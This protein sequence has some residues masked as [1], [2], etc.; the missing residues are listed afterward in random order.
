MTGGRQP[1]RAL[2][3]DHQAHKSCTS[4]CM[5]S[6]LGV[7]HTH[8]QDPIDGPKKPQAIWCSRRDMKLVWSYLG[9]LVDLRV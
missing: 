9:V 4:A 7:I 3:V 5:A 2:I 6:V 1:A 8:V